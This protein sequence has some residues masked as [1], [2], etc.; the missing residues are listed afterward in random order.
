MAKRNAS[1][2]E[3]T[4]TL[5]CGICHDLVRDAVQTACCGAGFC[6]VCLESCA[7]TCPWCRKAGLVIL[8][9]P[10]AERLAAAKV[11]RCTFEGNRAALR[12]HAEAKSACDLRAHLQERE[13]AALRAH[14]AVLQ[15]WLDRAREQRPTATLWVNRDQH[16]NETEAFLIPDTDFN[17]RRVPP[18]DAFCSILQGD[19]TAWARANMPESARD[20]CDNSAFIEAF[21]KTFTELGFRVDGPVYGAASRVVHT[22]NDCMDESCT[23]ARCRMGVR[24]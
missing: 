20:V 12:A 23:A 19:P 3:D 13:L 11:T 10:R 16:D 9:D 22:Q 21:R 24:E 1:S 8:A 15:N 17:T 2:L 5:Q 7:G 4:I 6:R 14:N 18:F